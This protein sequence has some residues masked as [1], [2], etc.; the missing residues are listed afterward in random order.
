MPELLL[1]HEAMLVLEESAPLFIEALKG[2]V[3]HTLHS[4]EAWPPAGAIRGC[5]GR[6]TAKVSLDFIV[7][8]GTCRHWLE[9]EAR[10]IRGP[11]FCRVVESA[12]PTPRMVPT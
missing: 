4:D 2:A 7:L 12:T 5:E 10:A 6:G 11:D 1:H 9:T 3:H 8:G